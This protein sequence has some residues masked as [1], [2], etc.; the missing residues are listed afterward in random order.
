MKITISGIPGSGKS[1]IAKLI[2][3]RLGYKYYSIGS[4]RREFAQRHG[5]TINELN[6]LKENTDK[7]FDE[8]QAEIGRNNDNIVVDGRLAY[9]FI[10]DSIKIYFDCDE[11]VA[12]ERI[13]KNQRSTEKKYGTLSQALRAI[14]MRVKNDKKRYLK[15]YNLNPFDKENYDYIIDTTRLNVKQVL[16]KVLNILRDK[17]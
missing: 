14:R 16:N 7:Q 2:A 8:F 10:P 5:L 15:L 11:N 1:T 9:Y 3:E 17:K 12:A 13:F 4:M 6:N